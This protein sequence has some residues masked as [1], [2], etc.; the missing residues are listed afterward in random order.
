[1]RSVDI[2]VSESARMV[3]RRIRVSLKG[4]KQYS[5]NSEQICEQIIKDC[6]TK[7]KNYFMVSQGHFCEFYARD[8]GWCS[9]ALLDLGYEQEVLNTLDYA[10]GVFR[11]TSMRLMPWLLSCEA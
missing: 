9:E 4:V 7:E 6:Y 8:F 3:L 1:M 2:L 10:L 5:G 11:I